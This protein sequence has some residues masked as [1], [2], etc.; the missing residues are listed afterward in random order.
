MRHLTPMIVG[1]ASLAAPS[2]PTQSTSDRYRDELQPQVERFVAQEHVPGL[3]IA[4]VEDH[5]VTYAHG[6]GVTALGDAGQPVT[7]RTLFHVASTTKP[8]VAT[9]VM[10]LVEQGALDLDGPVVKTLPYFH[11]ADERCKDITVRQLLTHSSGMPDVEDYEWDKPQFDDGALE[12]Y[13]RSLGSQKLLTAP[14][15][16]FAYSN[17]AYDVLGDVIAKASGTSFEAYVQQHI[18]TPLG[19]TGSTLLPR[20]AD[21][22]QL[23]IGHERNAAGEI[24]ALK[25]A[26]YNRIHSPSSNLLSSVDDM[27][28]WALANLA[29]GTLDGHRILKDETYTAMWTTAFKGAAPKA[30]RS[31][32][33]VGLCWALG[34]YQGHPAVSHAGGDTGFV[35]DFV[36][37]PDLGLGVVWMM[38]ADWPRQVSLTNTALDIALEGSRG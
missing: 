10:Q 27:A 35:C 31:T 20:E 26:P 5:R 8:F 25:A 18:L 34:D 4:V 32:R 38:N 19:M 1:L 30:W 13:V 2:L 16:K 33:G 17:M 36:L 29:R 15:A 9:A 7:T 11:L 22:K 37:L 14:G 21:P 6:F 24:A 12:R 28:R 3:A 23:A